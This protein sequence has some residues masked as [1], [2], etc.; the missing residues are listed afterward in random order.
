[1]A[2]L[3]ER[4]N[5]SR[6]NLSRS[7]FLSSRNLVLQREQLYLTFFKKLLQDKRN[8]CEESHDFSDES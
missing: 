4:I 5:I 2:L 1:M 3:V 8:M 6:E 7:R